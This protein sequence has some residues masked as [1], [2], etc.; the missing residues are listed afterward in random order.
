M[1]VQDSKKRLSNINYLNY[2]TAKESLKK[3]YPKHIFKNTAVGRGEIPY[4][5]EDVEMYQDYLRKLADLLFEPKGDFQKYCWDTIPAVEQL[6]SERFINGRK[7]Y[8]LS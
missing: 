1:S 8:D 4:P 2:Y 6:I 3:E 7:P 5:K